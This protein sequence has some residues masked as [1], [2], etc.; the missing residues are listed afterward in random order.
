MV[1]KVRLLLILVQGELRDRC[2]VIYQNCLSAKNTMVG[3]ITNVIT[4]NRIFI[5]E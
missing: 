2:A 1:I 5:L 4:H 3:Q